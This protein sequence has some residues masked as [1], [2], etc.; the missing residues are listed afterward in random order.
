MAVMNQ[1]NKTVNILMM[2]IGKLESINLWRSQDF[3]HTQW[4]HIELYIS[5]P[6]LCCCI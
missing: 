4:L 1:F 3:F 5:S 2:E 6:R